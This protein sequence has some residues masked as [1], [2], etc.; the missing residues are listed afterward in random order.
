MH[1]LQPDLSSDMFLF[2]VTAPR[3]AAAQFTFTSTSE[4]R[5]RPRISPVSRRTILDEFSARNSAE[6]SDSS[7]GEL[8]G[9]ATARVCVY[10]GLLLITQ[11]RGTTSDHRRVFFLPERGKCSITF[12]VCWKRRKEEQEK[13]RKQEEEQNSV[14][15]E[16]Q[17]RSEKFGPFRSPP[18]VLI[19]C[20][21]KYAS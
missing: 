18:L 9:D 8:P 21:F 11:L 7:H 13:K 12:T 17:I 10:D 14:V 3:A 20:S 16:E 4:R 2:P 5:R 19:H 6:A 1:H 15:V